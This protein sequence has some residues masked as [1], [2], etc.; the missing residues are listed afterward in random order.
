[1]L[2]ITN[3]VTV[4]LGQLELL[5]FEY[6]SLKHTQPGSASPKQKVLLYR[7]KILVAVTVPSTKIT[8]VVRPRALYRVRQLS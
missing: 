1:M 8:D 3:V 2:T 4:S 6:F 7:H 5:W